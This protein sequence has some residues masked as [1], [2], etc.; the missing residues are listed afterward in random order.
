MAFS[1]IARG[2]DQPWRQASV[3]SLVRWFALLHSRR[4]LRRRVVLAHRS[5]AGEGSVRQLTPS[6]PSP[7]AQAR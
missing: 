6:T 5:L 1:L 7:L 2:V 4:S 3:N